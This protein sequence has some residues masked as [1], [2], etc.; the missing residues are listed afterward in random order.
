MEEVAEE[1]E[2]GDKGEGVDSKL[3]KLLDLM[4]EH[5]HK[6]KEGTVTPERKISKQHPVR[7]V[8][9]LGDRF[10]PLLAFPE[11]PSSEELYEETE[12]ALDWFFEQE[13]PLTAEEQEM[14]RTATLW[15]SQPKIYN[16][17]I[18]AQLYSSLPLIQRRLASLYMTQH[19]MTL[20]RVFRPHQ[21]AL[22]DLISKCTSLAFLQD[23]AHFLNIFLDARQEYHDEVARTLLR[24]R[25][26]DYREKEMYRQYPLREVHP[27]VNAANELQK[28][29]VYTPL[30]KL[31]IM[32]MKEMVPLHSKDPVGFFKELTDVLTMGI[33]TLTD[34]TIIQKN[35]LP[36]GIYEKLRGQ[37]WLVDNANLN[38]AA[39]ETNDNARTAGADI[40]DD[41]K[42]APT[43]ILKVLPQLLT[44]RKEDW[45][46]IS[47]CKQKPGE[48]IGDYYTRLEKY[49]TANSGL[50]LES[51]SYAHLF[52]SKLVENSLPK[53]RERVQKCGPPL[54]GLCAT[55]CIP[56]PHIQKKENVKIMLQDHI[57]DLMA[58][59][60][61]DN[62]CTLV[63][64]GNVEK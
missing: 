7:C 50:K 2:G 18:I 57:D 48:D 54:C 13:P 34:L 32:K 1:E 47:A 14:V 8:P 60:I 62:G 56:K 26:T 5:R 9:P 61:D 28:V 29:F 55:M 15:T 10:A 35:L 3:N 36:P 53:L 33:Y 11:P 52:V 22:E 24:A 37:D 64:G 58:I 39:L 51:D 38:W 17:D 45:D 41:V 31:E 40:P 23:P 44:T 46:A 4:R 49:F 59:E 30:T 6:F 21:S 20:N 25:N 43:L 27:R 63:Q 16:S 42:L 12:E 19:L